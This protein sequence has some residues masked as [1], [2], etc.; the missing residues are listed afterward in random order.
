MCID[1]LIVVRRTH[2]PG[3]AQIPQI[4]PVFSY[5]AFHQALVRWLDKSLV[6]TGML[7]VWFQLAG[8]P[9]GAEIPIGRKSYAAV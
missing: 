4:D 8:S 3:T 7:P 1:R 2:F 9:T 6:K 5:D